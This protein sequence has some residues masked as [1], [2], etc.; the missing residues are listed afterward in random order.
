[1]KLT[2]PPFK[3]GDKVTTTYYPDEHKIVRTV[4]GIYTHEGCESG[5]I[6]RAD[7]GICCP[8]CNRKGTE[9]TQPP[10]DSYWFKLT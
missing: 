6:V 1:M 9:I 2:K 10:L 3:L 5:Y 4:I 8:T 7:G